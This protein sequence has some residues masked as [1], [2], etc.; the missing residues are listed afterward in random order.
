MD[1]ER[2]FLNY[3]KLGDDNAVA[4]SNGTSAL[5][6]LVY[7]L[8]K[9]KRDVRHKVEEFKTKTT[10]KIII[11]FTLFINHLTFLSHQNL[12]EDLSIF[13]SHS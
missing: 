11:N 2:H 9:K 8:N 5:F 4:L 7:L 6:I 12:I 13:H 10:K 3:L 1:D